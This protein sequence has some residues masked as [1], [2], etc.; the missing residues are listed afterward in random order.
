MKK[1]ILI[2]VLI[3]LINLF[4]FWYILDNLTSESF[5]SFLDIGQGSSVL[6]FN[7]KLKILYDIG[8]YGLKTIS[9]LNKLT[10]F[11]NRTI[12]IIIISHPDKD[13]Y[14]AI[15]DILERYKVRLIIV[16]PY[17]SQESGYLSFLNLVQKKNIPL[18]S[19]KEKDY[20]E[21]NFEKL[22]IIHPDK[23][24]KN[25]NQNSL[26]IELLKNNKKFLL[27]GD[28]DQ[29]IENHLLSKYGTKIKS[30]YL[31]IPHHGSKYSSNKYFLAN[32]NYAVIQVGENRYNHPHQE[33]ILR[34][35]ELKIPYWRTDLNGTFV[36]K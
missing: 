21:S 11:Y 13:H 24:Y 27:T 9:E 3:I 33:V 19:L 34:L 35:K 16:N 22:L 36:V 31:L 17:I 23:Q 28:I 8:P 2:L 26:V 10:K 14:G 25:D 18:I 29:K 4:L 20:L 6:I 7:P 15:F 5:V 30:D 12:D 1:S 32:F